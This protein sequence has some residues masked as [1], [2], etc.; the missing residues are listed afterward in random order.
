[1][2]S[3]QPMNGHDVA[4]LKCVQKE[5]Q[6]HLLLQN[7]R[8]FIGTPKPEVKGRK[9]ATRLGPSQIG[10]DN[11]KYVSLSSLYS[12]LLLTCWPCVSD[13]GLQA[14][15]NI[16]QGRQIYTWVANRKHRKSKRR[17]IHTGAGSPKQPGYE[18]TLKS[19]MYNSDEGF[20]FLF[21]KLYLSNLLLYAQYM[22]LNISNST[23]QRLAT[24]SIGLHIWPTHTISDKRH[25]S[26]SICL[27]CQND[28]LHTADR[29]SILLY[30]K[31]VT[32]TYE[33]LAKLGPMHQTYINPGHFPGFRRSCRTQ[34]I[35]AKKEAGPLFSGRLITLDCN[36]PATSARLS[37]ASFVSH[38]IAPPSCRAVPSPWLDIRYGMVSHALALRSLHRVFSQKFLSQTFL[39]QLK[40][41]L[42]GRVGVGNA[43]EQ[44]HLKR[45]YINACNE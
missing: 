31:V 40:A 14:W 21:L 25:F 1:M 26:S 37:R 24:N 2:W 7:E 15:L 5:L 30:I 6:V 17:T 36:I 20:I 45:R 8:R 12:W 32:Q 33:Q 42:F 13:V 22:C 41:V 18:A 28:C 4:R 27:L 23:Q 44:P 38:L 39:S 11:T 43:S 34:D 35:K 19:C 10:G 16:N 9:P 29:L 3:T